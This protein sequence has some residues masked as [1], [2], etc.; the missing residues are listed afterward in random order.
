[1]IEHLVNKVSAKNDILL[2]ILITYSVIL[3]WKYDVILTYNIMY[4]IRWSPLYC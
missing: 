4:I 2:I 1:M 3:I